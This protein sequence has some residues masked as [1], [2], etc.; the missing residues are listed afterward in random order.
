MDYPG[1]MAVRRTAFLRSGCYNGDVLFE[2]LELM[3]TL[4]AGGARNTARRQPLTT[5]PFSGRSCTSSAH[6]STPN[7]RLCGDRAPRSG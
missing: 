4:R 6:E 3:R 7:R 5:T 1:T 2:N